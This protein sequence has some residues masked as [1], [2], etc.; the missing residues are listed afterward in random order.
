M[1]GRPRPELEGLIGFFVNTLVL[2]AD[3][4]G[5][6]PFAE[7]VERVR[8]EALAAYA[9]QEVP[10]EKLVAE[11]ATERDRARSPLVQAVFTLQNLPAPAPP[12]PGAPAFTIAGLDV[13]PG[14]AAF[15]L[16]VALREETGPEGGLAGWILY[17]RDRFEETT[18]R[19][20]VAAYR[21]LLEAAVA[22]PGKRVGRLPLLD[23]AERRQVLEEWG[24]GEPL[25][26]GP[27]TLHG[28]FGE[29]AARTPDAVAL[30]WEGGALTYGGLAGV[31]SRLARRLR[32]LGIGPD[33]RVG[34][35][36]H[37]S[38]EFVIATLAVLEAGGAYLPLDP[39]Y[40]AER[41][42][43]ILADAG[44]PLVLAS[45]ATLDRLPPAPG[46]RTVLVIDEGPQPAD[47]GAEPSASGGG[48]EQPPRARPKASLI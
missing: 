8:A 11:L 41:L 22:D 5:D 42:A 37:R 15:D 3:L 12:P 1:A 26:A 24:P 29:W 35:C 20:L 38:P 32:A 16:T 39:D 21:T 4:T 33:V 18:V 31:A 17:D 34:L 9:H 45:R 36:L 43:W 30:A 44:A 19:G 47:S 23:A 13:P 14:A 46:E 7:L 28:R 48:L 25:A 10:F 27:K 2:R 6:P 40:P